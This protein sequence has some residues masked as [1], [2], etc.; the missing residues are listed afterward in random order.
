MAP[1][2]TVTAVKGPRCLWPCLDLLPLP[3]LKSITRVP[4]PRS[5]FVTASLMS[6]QGFSSLWHAL[7]LAAPVG[8]QPINLLHPSQR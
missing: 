8:R 7:G 6:A 2:S 4:T 5:R 1:G 3:P